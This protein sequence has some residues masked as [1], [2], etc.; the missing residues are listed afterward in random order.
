MLSPMLV[1]E[2]TA[3]HALGIAAGVPK[4]KLQSV[5]RP[6]VERTLANFFANGAAA[7]FSGPLRRGDV[8][9]IKRHVSALKEI[10]AEREVY[11]ALAKY[12]AST[13]PTKKEQAIRRLLHER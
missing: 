4:A 1:S 13:L 12:A 9:T 8:D 7:A 3:A 5:M 6:I 2:M 10:P 11:I